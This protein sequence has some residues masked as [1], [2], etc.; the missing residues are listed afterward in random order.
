[1]SYGTG[2]R[3]GDSRHPPLAERAV[4]GQTAII[5]YSRKFSK[6]KNFEKASLRIIRNF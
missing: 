5:L 4:S 1:M 6:A 2:K 3:Y